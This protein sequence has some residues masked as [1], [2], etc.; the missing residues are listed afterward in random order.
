MID[1]AKQLANERKL[2][3]RITAFISQLMRVRS[4]RVLLGQYLTCCWSDQ[5]GLAVNSAQHTRCGSIRLVGRCHHTHEH[6][7]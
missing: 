3:I 5:N 7:L 4:I 1:A 2:P 6:N